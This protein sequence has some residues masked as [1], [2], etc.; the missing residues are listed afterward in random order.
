RSRQSTV[1]DCGP[2][3][4]PVRSLAMT[5]LITRAHSLLAAGLLFTSISFAQDPP[6]V[7]P[8]TSDFAEK[9]ESTL[10]SADF[11]R[12]EAMVPM[13]DGTKLYTTWI[14]KKGVTKGPVLL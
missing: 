11:V 9:Y 2:V 3:P 13:R 14:F 8:M 6:R 12:R 5:H 1:E 10:P 7:T 4:G